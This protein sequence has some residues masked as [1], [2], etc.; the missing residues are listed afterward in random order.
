MSGNEQEWVLRTIIVINCG[1]KTLEDSKITK[2]ET[3]FLRE[4]FF[5]ISCGRHDYF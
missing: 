4:L 3:S 1:T 5:L 2:F